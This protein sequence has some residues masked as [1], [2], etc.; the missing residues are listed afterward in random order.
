M[1]KKKLDVPREV[2]KIWQEAKENLKVLGQKTIKLAQKGEKEV[3]RASKI[4]KLQLDIVSIN[5]NKENAFRQAGKKAYEMHTKKG[6]VNS[7][8]LESLFKQIDKLNQ[9][10]KTKKSKIGKLKK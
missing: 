4:G 7:V 3:V 8:K 6:N 5:L 10:V 2:A 1:V 9:Q